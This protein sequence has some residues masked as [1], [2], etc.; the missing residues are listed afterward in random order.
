M[1]QKCS[2]T[3][4]VTSQRSGFNDWHSVCADTQ[5]VL[6][7]FH[8]QVQSGYC[9]CKPITS[10]TMHDVKYTH[11][12]KHGLALIVKQTQEVKFGNEC[13]ETKRS[14][15]FQPLDAELLVSRCSLTFLVLVLTDHLSFKTT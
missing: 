14:G 11:L 13:T 8:F 7:F 10:Y 9:R 3:S 1:G 5:T 4:H 6:W 12:V 2:V 15:H